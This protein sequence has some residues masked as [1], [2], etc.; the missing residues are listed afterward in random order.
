DSIGSAFH[1]DIRPYNTLQIREN[2]DAAFRKVT[3]PERNWFARKLFDENL[4][5]IQSEDYRLMI[6]P[7]MNVRAGRENQS[8]ELIY[9]NTR[10][11]QFSG[12]LGN[13]FAFYADFYENQARFP[14]YLRESITQRK[15]IPGEGRFKV[16]KDGDAQDWGFATGMIY[17][18][19][20]K[21]FDFEFGQGKN[22]IGDG[23][24]SL[25]LSDNAFS[26]PFLKI[27][28]S[29]WRLQYVNLFTQMSDIRF[30][31]PNGTFA[32]KYVT[33]HYLSVNVT[34]RLNVGL[35]ETVIYEDSSG[36]RGYDVNYLNPIIFYRPIEF[37]VGS[38]SGNVLIGLNV[39]YRMT[40]KAH[41]Y[42][43]FVLDEFKFDEIK[44]RSGWW[45]NKF[46]FQLGVKGYDF[47]LPGLTAQTEVNFVRP[48]T[49]S[50]FNTLQ[51]YGHYNQPLAH[52]L[53]A[54]FVENVTLISY[55]KDRW[56]GELEIMYA[57]QGRDTLNSNWGTDVYKDYELRERDYDNKTG[58]GVHARTLYTDVKV[59][60]LFNPQT[61][62]RLEVGFSRRHF[63]P[64]IETPELKTNTTNYFY[65]GLTTALTNR[66]YDF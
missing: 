53:G 32:R 65:L 21:F 20:N 48:Y 40:N 3:T 24:R 1:T 15:V 39:K 46:G 23:Y 31:K 44:A 4:V 14:E 62:L 35:F 6:N 27:T 54:N 13:K 43:Q 50:H 33:A 57:A 17:F 41:L 55:H 5:D 66:Y 56:F 38:S 11:V 52:P 59:G 16:F 26:Y 7:L 37:A 34:K 58:Q 18:R 45:A 10:G 2:I 60:Y 29:V 28:T 19:P 25:L 22:F 8:D 30:K 49:Y 47:L 61:N 42:G 36:T 51:N 63:K 9:T 64:E 12:V